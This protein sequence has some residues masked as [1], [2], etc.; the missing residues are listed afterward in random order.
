MNTSSETGCCPR[1]D[2]APWEEKEV[3]WNDKLFVKCRVRSFFHFPLN[4]GALMRR[5]MPL[6]EA[7][8][9]LED[10]QLLLCDENSLW[11]ADL[12]IAVTREVPGFNH[13]LSGTYLTKV[14][15]GP[16]RNV[17]TWC[18]DMQSY[19]KSKGHELKKLLFFYTT[20][21]KSAKVYGKN[22]VVL[23]AQV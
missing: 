13:A 12:Y 16:F 22:Y 5:N 23:L 17:R 15:E 20:C 4:F 9:A 7:A 21:P 10:P 11:G 3:H 8:K 14:Y 19:V 18:G 1:F 6:L 2:P